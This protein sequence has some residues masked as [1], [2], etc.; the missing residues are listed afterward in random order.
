M[1]ESYSFFDSKD[2]DRVYRARHWADYFYP[3]FKSGVFNGN[4]QVVE[5]GGMRV[6][7]SGGYAWI[8]GYLYHLTDGLILDLETASG[9]MNR[10]DNIV[11]RL[12]LTNRWIRGFVVSGNYYQGEATPPERAVTSIVHELVIARI[13]VPAGATQI[14]QDMIEDTRMNNDLC[15]WVVGTVKEI[16]YSQIYAQFTAYQSR[17]V[18]EVDE[19]Q[20]A[21]EAAL[22]AWITKLKADK[23]AKLQEIVSDFRDMEAGA[24]TRIN[25]WIDT[26][27]QEKTAQSQEII[28]G[29]NEL[30]ECAESDFTSWFNDNTGVWTAAFEAWFSNLKAQLTTNAA[31]NLQNQI[32]NLTDLSTAE[33]GSLTG[34][35]NEV[36]RQNGKETDG[37]VSKGKNNPNRVWATDENGNPAWRKIA[38]VDDNGIKLVN[39][40]NVSLTNLDESVLIKWTDPVDLTLNGST[41][42]QWDG[43]VVVRK[44]GSKPTN[45]FDGVIVVDSKTRD[46]YKS[47][48]FTDNGLTNGVTYYYGIFP[49]TKDK[50]YNYS[51][52]TSITPSRIYPSA[53]T[54]ITVA[55]GNKEM[56]VSYT[57]PSDA[58]EIKI[59]Y[60]TAE[61]V[62]TDT[63]TGTVVNA[64]ASPCRITGLKNDTLYYVKVISKNAKGRLKA[65]QAYTVTPRGVKIVTWA[66][67]TDAEIAA[68]LEAHYAGEINISDFWAVGDERTISISAMET[69]NDGESNTSGESHSAQQV[70]FVIVGFD[71]DNL[72]TAVNG[73]TKA[74]VSAH[75]KEPLSEAG[76]IDKSYKTA[77]TYTK[78][79]STCRRRVNWIN[80]IFKGS[81]PAGIQTLIKTVRKETY[82]VIV[83]NE[84]AYGEKETTQDDCYLLSKDEVGKGN[85]TN[86]EGETYEYYQTESHRVKNTEYWIRTPRKAGMNRHNWSS[87]TV[88]GGL[89]TYGIPASSNIGIAVGFSI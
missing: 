25:E 20:A 85:G 53:P 37:Y 5:N 79:W 48:G 54:G 82:P 81:L 13:N 6:K 64:T 15:G 34:A 29:L 45:R 47:N 23:T 3:L 16:D 84:E 43:T 60:G 72:V 51:Y 7:I 41:L 2:H 44:A 68:M 19:W 71:H 38:D 69:W 70:K 11:I 49:Y 28:D 88:T 21:E 76:A 78:A 42:A 30:T 39:P 14:T 77:T 50:A 8:D 12:D 1:A 67:G 86:K 62:V 80:S 26:L 18:K 46:K 36:N 4:L 89:S 65:S 32:G 59:A 66:G 87:I 75:M 9:N 58:T 24:E 74:A 35:I 55:F 33:K 10:I 17:K 22:I 61:P 73:H 40:S 27:K 83:S 31:T 56:T 63:I 57:K 52:T